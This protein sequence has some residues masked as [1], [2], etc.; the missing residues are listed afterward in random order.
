MSAAVRTNC[1]IIARRYEHQRLETLHGSNVKWLVLSD[2]LFEQVCEDFTIR[3]LSI[4]REA[5]RSL[6]D[7]ECVSQITYELITKPARPRRAQQS[8]SQERAADSGVDFDTGLRTTTSCPPQ[9]QTNDVR[10]SPCRYDSATHIEEQA[11][12]QTANQATDHLDPRLASE[13]RPS[14]IDT[15]LN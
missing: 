15:I 6:F 1:H 13:F 8:R 7:A 5:K 11:M 14:W 4:S 9:G 3:R 10:P 2:E 12:L